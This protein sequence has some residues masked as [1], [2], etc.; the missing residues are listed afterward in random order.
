MLFERKSNGG[1]EVMDD[2][3]KAAAL[4]KSVDFGSRVTGIGSLP[5]V[6]PLEACRRVLEFCP[7]IPYAPQLS[8]R[9]PGENMFLQFS[10][11]LPCLKTDY[12]KNQLFFD[13]TQDREKALM[14]FYDCLGNN[15]YEHFRISPERAGGFYAMLEESERSG[16]IFIKT[17]VTG[18]VTYL[19]SVARQEGCPVIF[20]DEFAEALTLGL[21]MKGLWQVRRIREKGKIPVLFFDEPSLWGLG[22]AYMPVSVERSAYLIGTLINFIRDHD[23]GLLLGLHCCGNTD[24]GMILDSGVDIV[25]FDAYSFGDRLALYGRE[26]GEFLRRGG[27]FAFGVVPT[28]EYTNGIKEKELFNRFINIMKVFEGKGVPV[29]VLLR[30]AIFTPACGMGPLSPPDAEK[31]L[32][33]TAS[34]TRQIRDKYIE[35]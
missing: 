12:E 13:D 24:W 21:G 18:P 7:Q 19:L 10:E 29:E 27:I 1:R 34:L 6:D 20:D 8:K 31:V 16:N 22:S 9:G 4:L 17:Q 28:S 23:R 35:A 15:R 25:S 33:L 2:R 26:T 3:K 5:F 30:S 11:N 14:E 32:S